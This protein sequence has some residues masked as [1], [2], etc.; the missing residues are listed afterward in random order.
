MTMFVLSPSV[1]TTT[2][3]ASSIPA[4][5][6]TSMSIPW[7]STKPPA[8]SSEA[9]ESLLLLV[10]GGHVPPLA[11]EL[12]GEVRADAAAAD[13]QSLHMTHISSLPRR[14][15]LPPLRPRERPRR[16][17]RRAPCAAHIRPSV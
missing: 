5:R 4:R 6:R 10:H 3:S 14:C 15:R 7:P 12:E 16:A 13:H 8:Q 11:V 17:P 1:A 9:A 2:A